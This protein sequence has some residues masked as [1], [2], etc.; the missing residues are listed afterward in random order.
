MLVICGMK[1]VRCVPKMMIFGCRDIQG[2]VSY[3]FCLSSMP[4]S[5]V[6][7]KLSAKFI[8]DPLCRHFLTGDDIGM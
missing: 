8:S 6:I 3:N 2:R 1:L 7:P 4:R 5:G